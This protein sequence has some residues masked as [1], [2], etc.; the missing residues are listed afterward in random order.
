M[1]FTINV[2]GREL[3]PRVIDIKQYSANVDTVTFV[4]AAAP[5]GEVYVIDDTYRLALNVSDN[6][7]VWLI[8]AEFTQR[9]GGRNMQI[10]VV[11]GDEIFRSSVMAVNISLSEGGSVP[12]VP[13][14]EGGYGV[15]CDAVGLPFAVLDMG[16]VGS[17]EVIN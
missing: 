7:A 8:P 6:S 15:V 3:N 14:Q 9:A 4:F 5:V 13:P 1:D 17:Y 16:I 2:E 12:I 11:N 10:E